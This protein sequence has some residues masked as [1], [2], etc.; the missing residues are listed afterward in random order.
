MRRDVLGGYLR[1]KG[2]PHGGA[3]LR[4]AAWWACILLGMAL[5]VAALLLWFCGREKLFVSRREGGSG[6]C[7]TVRVFEVSTSWRLSL[8]LSWSSYQFVDQHGLQRALAMR[9]H[10]SPTTI[11]NPPFDSDFIFLRGGLPPRANGF[12]WPQKARLI[13]SCPGGTFAYDVSGNCTAKWYGG[14]YPW[15]PWY[16]MWHREIVI[17]IPARVIFFTGASLLGVLSALWL[18]RHRPW[19]TKEGCCRK[20]GYD[21]RAHKPGQRCPECGT[22]IPVGTRCGNI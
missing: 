12:G 17:W 14:G 5:V 22:V 10:P 3:K 6:P 2:T 21:L 16:T 11:D 4:C 8:Q 19:Q 9:S 1:E 15:P 13:G 20:C 7:R 18:V